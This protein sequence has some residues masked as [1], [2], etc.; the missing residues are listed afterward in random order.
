MEDIRNVLS[1]NNTK[2]NQELF[3]KAKLELEI[4]WNK[5]TEGAKVRSKEQWIQE[6]EKN[7]KY[8]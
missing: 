2:E 4:A 6:G 7:T 5:K 8:F 1:K 3:A